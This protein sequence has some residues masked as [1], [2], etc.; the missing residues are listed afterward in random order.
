MIWLLVW[1]C[2]F[3]AGIAGTWIVLS[4]LD[5]RESGPTVGVLPRTM[6]GIGEPVAKGARGHRPTGVLPIYRDCDPEPII[7]VK[8]APDDEPGTWPEL[9]P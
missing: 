3:Y 8:Q 5:R 4:W 1:A 7:L 9:E 2:C 6:G